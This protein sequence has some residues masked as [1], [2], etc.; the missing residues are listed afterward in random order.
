MMILVG[1]LYKM[2]TSL[3]SSNRVARLVSP[4]IELGDSSR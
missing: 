2:M 1:V 3:N 4:R